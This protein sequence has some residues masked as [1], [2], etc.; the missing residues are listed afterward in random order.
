MILIAYGLKVALAGYFLGLACA[1]Q[2]E[3]FSPK[4]GSASSWPSLLH[5]VHMQGPATAAAPVGARQ[6]LR[7]SLLVDNTLNRQGR[8]PDSTAGRAPVAPRR[9]TGWGDAFRKSGSLERT[10]LT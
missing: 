10:V 5:C 9:P 4:A 6:Q 8:P 7:V 3:I 2:S 1:S